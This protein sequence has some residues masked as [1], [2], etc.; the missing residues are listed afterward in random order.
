[1]LEEI[2]RHDLLANVRR[3]GE[4]LQGALEARF[5]QHPHVGDVRGRGLFH[6]IE[7]VA[8]RGSKQPFDRRLKLHARIKKA[9]MAEGLM[10]Y[11]MGGT[12]DGE[13]GDHVLLAPPYIVEETQVAEIVDRLDR[14]MTGVLREVAAA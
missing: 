6:G 5:G 3:Q 12:V 4:A 8:D 13:S 10:C 7:L 1:M 9:A 14:A 2:E 11:P